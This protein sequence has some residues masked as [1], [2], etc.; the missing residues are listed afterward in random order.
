[1]SE[2]RLAVAERNSFMR[3]R[4]TR[5]GFSWDGLT[6]FF[7]TVCAVLAC[8]LMLRSFLPAITGAV[9]L[10]I[11]TSYPHEWI[12]ARL[13]SRSLAAAASVALISTAIIGPAFFLIQSVAYHVLS[14]VRAIQSGRAEQEIQLFLDHSPRISDALQYAMDNVSVSQAFDKSA[15]FIVAQLGGVLGGSF[16]ALVQILIML[17]LLFFLYRDGQAAATHLRTMMPLTSEETDDLLADLT[18]TVR[19]I[20]LGRFTVAAI[21]GVAAGIAFACLGIPGAPLLGAMTVFVAP[22]PILGAFVVWV[23]TA[24]Y[25]AAMHHWVQAALLVLIGLLV[26]GTLDKVLFPILVGSQVRL[27]TAP[28]LL[29]ILG[30]IWLLGMWGLILGPVAFTIAHAFIG[31]WQRRFT[32]SE[33]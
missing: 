10:A 31:I 30:G 11:V 3:P 2:G 27:H 18:S 25:L 33:P 21:Q 9:V 16:N 5:R 7:L 23:P 32:S 8:F 15:G 17:L 14:A 22:I 13:K 28:V 20:V 12:A 19:A 6:L 29:S 26:V 1:M 24:I 4:I